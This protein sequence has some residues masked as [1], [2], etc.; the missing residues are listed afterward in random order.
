LRNLLREGDGAAQAGRNLSQRRCPLHLAFA[1][2]RW[3]YYFG[4]SNITPGILPVF[5]TR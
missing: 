5:A 1:R 4:P 2:S 3:G